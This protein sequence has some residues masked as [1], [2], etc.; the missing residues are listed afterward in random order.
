M[1]QRS[2]VLSGDFVGQMTNHHYFLIPTTSK[3]VSD[4][5]QVI[6]VIVRF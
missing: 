5:V 1:G 3:S 6:P 4:K 2:V